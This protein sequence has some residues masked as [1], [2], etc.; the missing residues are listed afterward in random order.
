MRVN[1]YGRIYR[2]DQGI[3]KEVVNKK[4]AHLLDRVDA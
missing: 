1:R 2:R 4:R 3:E